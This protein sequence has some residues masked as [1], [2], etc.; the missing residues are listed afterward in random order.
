MFQCADNDLAFHPF[1]R[2]GVEVLVPPPTRALTNSSQSNAPELTAPFVSGAAGVK[3]VRPMT[4]G[5]RKS[6][7]RTEPLIRRTDA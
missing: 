3:V 7:S 6:A 1:E 2:F 5:G 4:C